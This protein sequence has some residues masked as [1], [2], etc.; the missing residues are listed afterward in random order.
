M[1]RGASAEDHILR[2]HFV[3]L[4]LRHEEEPI[5]ETRDEGERIS[6]ESERVCRIRIHSYLLENWWVE[7]S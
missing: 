1:T 5:A 3:G 2:Y 6:P 7:R 4:N